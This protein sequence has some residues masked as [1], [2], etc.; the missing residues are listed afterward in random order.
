MK[1]PSIDA[2]ARLTTTWV[3]YNCAVRMAARLTLERAEGA[4]STTAFSKVMS[5][6]H[7]NQLA[8]TLRINPQLKVELIREF[9]STI[10]TKDGAPELRENNPVFPM[11]N[12]KYIPT[13]IMVADDIIKTKS[14]PWNEWAGLVRELQLNFDTYGVEVSAGPLF[15]NR[16]YGSGPHVSRVWTLV[17]P[18]SRSYFLHNR[19]TPM[20]TRA[21]LSSY[22]YTQESVSEPDW[23]DLVP[24]I[25][26]E[27]A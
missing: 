1:I 12:G 11:D 9:I 20:W 26:K 10:S 25:P 19:S 3:N 24:H 18:S 8:T 13:A 5:Y 6:D 21:L 15:Q 2:R 27:A 17:L 7:K 23:T 22:G 14:E 4:E 16:T